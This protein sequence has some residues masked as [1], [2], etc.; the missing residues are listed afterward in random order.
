MSFETPI[1]PYNASD[2]HATYLNISCLDLL[3]IEM[4]P[5]A[6]R[7]AR[8]AERAE[9]GE[10]EV[11]TEEDEIES[12]GAGSAK[13]GGKWGGKERKGDDSGSGGGEGQDGEVY[14]DAIF[15]RLDGLGYRVGQGLSERYVSLTVCLHCQKRRS[16]GKDVERQNTVVVGSTTALERHL[17][18]PGH[19]LS[20]WPSYPGNSLKPRSIE[21]NP[22]TNSQ[23]HHDHTERRQTRRRTRISC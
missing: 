22:H 2:P 14:R 10:L 8:R 19:F 17:Y 23:A 4:V 12:V 20:K 15:F 21:D 16:W 13:K 3:L 7:M 5:L 9:R 6:E 1:P 11:G 18:R